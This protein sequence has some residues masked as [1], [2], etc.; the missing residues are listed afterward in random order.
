MNMP[1]FASRNQRVRSLAKLK[2]NPTSPINGSD[3]AASESLMKSRREDEQARTRAEM[4]SRH[5]F[6]TAVDLSYSY[7]RPR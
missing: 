7:Q 5:L 1:N 2:A 3:D 6:D 4:L